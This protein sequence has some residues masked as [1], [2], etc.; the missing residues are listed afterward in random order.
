M[1]KQTDK[2]AQPIPALGDDKGEGDY[3]SGERYQREATEFAKSGKVEQAAEEA[4]EAVEG[5]EAD[6]LAAAEV[7]GRSRSKGEDE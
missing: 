4:K 2:P 7:K 6:D 3:E 5:D 1:S